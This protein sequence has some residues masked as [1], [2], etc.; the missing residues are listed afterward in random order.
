VITARVRP[1]VEDG[2]LL[3]NLDRVGMGRLVMPG[4][5][6]ERLVG[7]LGD[8]GSG[9]AL[10]EPAVQ[11]VLD[12]LSG[13]RPI[14][15]ALELADGRRVELLEIDLEGDALDLRLRTVS[16]RSADG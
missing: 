3:L 15:A 16:A 14:D 13:K 12:L 1:A 11:E 10:H 2:Q 4:E 6:M 9:T 7:L 5:P 8:A